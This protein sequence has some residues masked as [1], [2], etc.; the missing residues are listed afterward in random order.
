MVPVYVPATA[1][2][3][4]D[5]IT[6][7]FQLTIVFPVPAVSVKAVRETLSA[8]AFAEVAWPGVVVAVP[9]TEVAVPDQYDTAEVGMVSAGEWPPVVNVVL[10]TV[11]VQ[12]AL[13][14]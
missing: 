13:V 1:A 12:V 7:G 5:T 10:E 6:V 8:C 3:G 14:L 11:A 4:T 2:A 9:V